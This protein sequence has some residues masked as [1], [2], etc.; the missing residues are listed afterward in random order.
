MPRSEWGDLDRET[1]AFGLAKTG[2]PVSDTG[3]GQEVVA[4]KPVFAGKP[5]E[6]TAQCKPGNDLVT[7][8]C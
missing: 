7:A 8:S 1:Q 4:R 5:A 2:G 6:P 3:N